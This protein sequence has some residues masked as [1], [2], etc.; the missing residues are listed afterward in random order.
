MNDI[1]EFERAIARHSADRLISYKTVNGE[2][3]VLAL[4][5]PENFYSGKS[6]PTF[7]M[8][9]GGGWS[10]RKVFP[11]QP[12]WRGDYLG[13]LARYYADR[14]FVAVCIE[15]RLTR[16]RGQEPGFGLMELWADCRDAVDYLTTHC[17]ELGIDVN[18]M[19]ML[20]ESAGG[21]LAAALA[22][23][24][25]WQFPFAKVFLINPITELVTKPWLDF[26][27]GNFKEPGW[28]E[29][30]KALSPLYQITKGTCET[31]LIHGA[32]DGTVSPDHSIQ[33]CEEMKRQ[34][35][36]CTLHLLEKTTHAFLL[37][38]YYKGGLDACRKAVAIINQEHSCN[39]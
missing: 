31:V 4:F 38:E 36:Q 6:Y 25:N 29:R 12:S 9:H 32:E 10:T 20:G 5:F 22:T 23:D 27:P 28:K 33:F 15:Y 14:G 24:G 19:Y 39:P 3:L 8:I 37:A 16:N 30:A 7:C 2:E 26:V 34:G 35:N 21:Y 13:Y 1:T 11:D 17:G 18:R